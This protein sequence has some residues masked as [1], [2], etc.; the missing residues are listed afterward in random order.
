MSGCIVIAGP[1]GV[2]KTTVAEAIIASDKSFSY[3]ISATTRPA[4]GSGDEEY[5]YMSREEFLGIL[6]KG[7]ILEYTEYEGNLYGTVKEEM[8]RTV[9]DGK[10]PVLVLDLEGVKSLKTASLSYPVT[11]FYLY[12]DL[13]V[14]EERLYNRDLSTPSIE[15]LKSFLRRRKRNAEDFIRLSEYGAYIDF[16]IKNET[17]L[18]CAETVKKGLGKAQSDSEKSEILQKLRLMGEDKLSKI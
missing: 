13:N 12:D 4:R 3:L 11:T 10:T 16:F 9:Y 17:P 5:K 6:D 18:C 14:I 1:S 2:G 15:N 7:G 8:D